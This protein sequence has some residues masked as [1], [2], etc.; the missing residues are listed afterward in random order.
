MRRLLSP[1]IPVL[2]GITLVMNMLDV[3]LTSVVVTTGLAVEANPL[4]AALL[5]HGTAPFA[6][7][8]TTLVSAGIAVLFHFRRHP[9]A[10]AGAAFTFGCYALVMVQ[11]VR[12]VEAL[13]WLLTTS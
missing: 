7:I 1:T 10:I 9:L 4:M 11:H 8:K 5:E 6:I 13:A 3:V 2:L 12:S